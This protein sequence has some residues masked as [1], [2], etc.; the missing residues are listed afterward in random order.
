MAQASMMIF[1]TVSYLTNM[2]WKP[3]SSKFLKIL[4]FC[5]KFWKYAKI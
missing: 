4:K 1:E 3:F 2:L 5:S